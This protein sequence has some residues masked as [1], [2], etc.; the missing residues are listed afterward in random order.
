M[1]DDMPASFDLPAVRR[2]KLTASFDGGQLSSDGGLLLLREAERGLGIANRLAGAIRDRRDPS[3][4]DHAL[5]ELLKTRIFAI[6]CGYE[7]A[8]DLARLRHDP[9][10]K[11]AV[12]RCPRSG[13]PLCSQ[14][15]MSRLEN[16]PSRIEAARLTA[17]LVDQFCASFPRPPKTMMLDIDDTVDAVHGGQQLSFWN[18][19]HDCRCFLPIHVYH[20]ESGRPVVM[21]L[22]EGKTP[23]GAEVRTVIKHL[24]R[25]IRHHFPK[26]RITWRGDSHYGRPEAMRWCEDNASGF[27]FGLAGNPALDR[28]CQDVADDLCVRR[29]EASAQTMRAFASFSYQARSWDKPRKVVARIEATA[30]GLDIRYIVTSLPGRAQDLYEAVY[31]ERGQAENL[32]KLHKTQLASDRTS[33][34]SPVANQVRLVLHTAAY[35]LMLTLRNA[36]PRAAPLAKAEFTT[37]RAKLIKIA[38]RVIEHAARIRV[39]LPTGC[40]EQSW[41]GCIAARLALAVP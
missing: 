24:T 10:L 21:I 35:W 30:L 12:G 17:A 1:S 31:C 20:V 23:G 33:C 41:F 28:L 19:H 32:I 25:R 2:K 14:S 6:A 36:I 9:L 8:N 34:H 38:A 27:I 13:A 3:R 22:R 26:T 11:L 18:A 15:T 4:T 40:P 7:D 5:P 29:A 39:H 16:M 37:I